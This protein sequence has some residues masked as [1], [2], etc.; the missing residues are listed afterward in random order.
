[1]ESLQYLAQGLSV[2]LEPLNIMFAFF[3]CLAGTL[4]GVLPGIGP[5]SGVAL[6]IPVAAMATS[7]LP[8]EQAATAS[9]ILLAGVYYGAMYGGSTTA[10]LIN[11]PGENS[12]VCTTLDGYQM[13]KQ[14]RAGAALA[15][16]A[17]GSFVAGIIA[18]VGLIFLAVPLAEFALKFSPAG[19]FSL[20]ILGLCALSSLAGK[21]VIKAFIMTTFGLILSTVGVD[22]ISG[23]ARMTFNYSELYGGI[24]FL[25]LAVGMFALGEVFKTILTNDY[26]EGEAIKVGSIMPTKKDLKDSAMPILRGSL[27]GFFQGLIPGCGATLSS[28]M[29]YTFE[30][31]ISKNKA[32]F[33][34]GAIEG[35]AAPE[36]GNNGASGGAM[37]PLLT[38]GIPGTGTTAVLMGALVM[39][40]ITPGP[41]LF[42]DHPQVAWG[43]IASMLVGNFMLLVLNLPLVKVFAKVIET[44]PKYLIPGIVAI[45]VFGVYAVQGSVFN[46][47]LMIV[48]GVAAYYLAKNDYPIAPVV[49]SLIL[50]PMIENNLRR[51]MNLYNGDYTM[52]VKDPISLVFLIIAFLWVAVPQIMKLRGK[53]VVVEE[54]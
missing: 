16:C 51:A 31:K 37:I 38:L 11:T 19:Q 33:G 10:I 42:Q 40:N 12:S 25:T 22:P 13:A 17:I 29:V 3:G 23:V 18:C 44:P 27:L 7:S 54:G 24:E 45:S 15:I 20:M 14:G 21:S 6:L 39:F 49:L 35:V 30:K 52:F 46:L 48:S 1:M 47:F 8:M 34:K 5:I 2:A 32:N 4:V 53:T 9:I 28:F 41:L 43:L 50:G 26:I 36:A